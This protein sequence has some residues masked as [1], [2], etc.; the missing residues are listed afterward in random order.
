MKHNKPFYYEVAKFHSIREMLALAEKEASETVAFKFKNGEEI[1]SITYKEFIDQTEQLGAALTD[2]GYGSSHIAC[3]GNN[4]YKWVVT[5]LT[6]LKSAGVFVPVD[7]EL[8]TADLI[9]VLSDSD[10]SVVFYA[11]KYENILKENADKLPN[12]KFFVGLERT[13]DEGNFVS[14]DKLLEHGKSCDKQKYDALKSDPFALKMLVYTSGTTGASKGVMLSEH[15]LVSSVYYG[16]QVSTVYDTCLSVLPYNHT[17]EAVSGLLVSLHHHSTI[18]IND[19]LASV[20]KNLK[21]YKPSYV[22]L[23]PAFAEVFYANI[24]KTVKEQGK[25]KAFGMLIKTSNG[26]RKIGIDL[27]KKLFKQIHDNF[28]GRLIKIVC[29]GAPIRPE[30]GQFFDD[31]GINLINGYGI[32]ECSPLVCA[33]NDYFNDYHTAGIRLPCVEWRIDS[34]NGEGI[35]EICIKGDIV[36]LG[37]YKRP[38]LTA[39]VLKDGWFYTGDYGFINSKDQLI[40]TGRKKNII[41]LSNGKNVYPEEIE[42]YIQGISYIKEVLVKGVKNEMGSQN[43]LQAEVFIGEPMKEQ[44]V[45]KD[46][47]EVCK[48]LPVYKRVNSVVIRDEEFPKTTSKKIKRAAVK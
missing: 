19:S 26:L 15:N 22:Y 10:S 44:D 7:K 25:E 35:G 18:C 9:N 48:V 6:V 28:G 23:V 47:N 43:A 30:I 13:E 27:R 39:E 14:F 17:Y 45:L 21:L 5:Y 8:P 40:I 41:V 31:I 34:P 38:D 24:L 4:S 36:M 42:G 37:Y 1:V 46:I 2:A 20:A 11:K 16:M 3:L 29:G 33:N 32:T 12:I